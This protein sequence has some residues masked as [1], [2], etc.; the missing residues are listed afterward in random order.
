MTIS[1]RSLRPATARYAIYIA[2]TAMI[3]II[4]I[5][6]LKQYVTKILRKLNVFVTATSDR[7]RAAQRIVTTCCKPLETQRLGLQHAAEACVY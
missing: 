2:A 6:E 3:R 4:T 1:P 5:M 7:R